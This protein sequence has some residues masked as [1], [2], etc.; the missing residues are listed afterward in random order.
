MLKFL[1]RV[2]DKLSNYLAIRKGLLPILGICLVIANLLLR[3]FSTGWLASTDL[4]L[5]LGIIVA[6]LGF[7]LSW[8][9]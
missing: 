7:M 2:I 1:S 8:A 9:L 6:V 4:L 5:H 3:V